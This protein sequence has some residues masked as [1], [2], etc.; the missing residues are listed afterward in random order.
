[1]KKISLN[2][3]IVLLVSAALITLASV[4]SY[5]AISRS[6][7]ALIATTYQQLSAIRDSKKNQLIKFFT[8]R[9]SDISVLS[10]SHDLHNLVA[11]LE[12]IYQQLNIPEKASFPVTQQVVKS[13][14]APHEKF[15]QGYLKDYGYYDIFVISK[16]HGHVMYSAAKES[17][18]GENL[19]YG[20]LK[21]SGLAKIWKKTVDNNRTSFV[22]MT[23]YSPSN[24][25][26]AMFLGTP[27][28]KNGEFNS[29]LVFQIS[30]KAINEILKYRDGYGFSQE[31]YLV[32][33]DKLMRSDSFLDPKNHTLIASF[34]NPS[35][36]SVDTLATQKAFSGQTSTEV[37]I[38]YNGNP[39][40]SAYSPVTIG[41][42]INWVILSEIDEAEIMLIPSE[43]Q[44]AILIQSFIIMLIVIASSIFLIKMGLISP[45]NNFKHRLQ[46]ITKNKDLTLLLDTNAP[47]VV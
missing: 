46:T 36:G 39:V 20:A 9:Q 3:Q 29:I 13:R 19:R 28:E 47:D 14:T 5:S 11:D 15:F 21:N 16:E 30:D 41:K 38:D 2:L 45:L 4:I 17:D 6:T 1:M 35:L 23:P 7:D 44:K 43:I 40:L 24:N 22:D 12:Q 25:A 10:G 34:A 37:V 42:D 32:G 31:D 18:Y 26:P 27:I 8:E 33:E